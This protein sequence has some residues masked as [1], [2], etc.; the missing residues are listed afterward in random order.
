[1]DDMT[2]KFEEE[3]SHVQILKELLRRSSHVWLE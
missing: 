2:A 1:M 3:E